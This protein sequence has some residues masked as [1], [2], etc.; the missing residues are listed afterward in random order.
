M[1]HLNMASVFLIMFLV[2]IAFAAAFKLFLT[3]PAKANQSPPDVTAEDV[4]NSQ[5]AA[6]PP[7]AFGEA[8][9]PEDL[10]ERAGNDFLRKSS[11]SDTD[12]DVP[13]LEMPPQLD[14]ADSDDSGPH[15]GTTRSLAHR[16]TMPAALAAWKFDPILSDSEST[17]DEA[18]GEGEGEMGAEKTAP[19]FSNR[20][21]AP[22]RMRHTISV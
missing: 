3:L 15:L 1:A 20:N 4:V 16:P 14:S 21:H 17:E 22:R 9:V 8:G 10:N 11:D 18:Q 2:I 5:A 19:V 13:A 7:S 12:S 6:G